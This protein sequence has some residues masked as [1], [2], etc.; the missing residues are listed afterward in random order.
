[1]Q[2]GGDVHPFLLGPLDHPYEAGRT[3]H[4]EHEQH[5][6]GAGDGGHLELDA[7]EPLAD[8]QGRGG[9]GGRDQPPGRPPG[10]RCQRSPARMATDAKAPTTRF[11]AAPASG[12]SR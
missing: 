2:L 10:G 7:L 8:G 4:H 3:R 5:R 9:L 11:R 12:D 1:V 6:P